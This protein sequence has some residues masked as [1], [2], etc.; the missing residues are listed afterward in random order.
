MRIALI[1][2]FI[3]S[4][5]ALLALTTGP[6]QAAYHTVLVIDQSDGQST[7]HLEER[8]NTSLGLIELNSDRM[9]SSCFVGEAGNVVSI[10]KQMALNTVK[11]SG[12]QIRFRALWSEK[13]NDAFVLRVKAE[14]Q[15]SQGPWIIVDTTLFPCLAPQ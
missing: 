12:D 6:A 5:F 1:R 8:A 13:Q 10:I 9:I 2:R 7:R 3:L 4:V 14:V 15:S 11:T